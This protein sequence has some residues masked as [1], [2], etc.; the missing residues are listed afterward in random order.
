MSAKSAVA[1]KDGASAG[2]TVAE[3]GRRVAEAPSSA[4]GGQKRSEEEKEAA[5]D[6]AP[7]QPPVTKKPKRAPIEEA[8]KPLTKEL[9]EVR[10]GQSG[11]QGIEEGDGED[12]RHI[13]WH[14]LFFCVFFSNDSWKSDRGRDFF[15]AFPWRTL[16]HRL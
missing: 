5:A 15:H 9:P 10:K 14:F 12:A 3:E 4:H 8:P 2:D 16:R 13:S 7:E 6:A 11:R 1:Q